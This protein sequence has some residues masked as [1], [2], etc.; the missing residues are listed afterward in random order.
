MHDILEMPTTMRQLAVVQFFTWFALFS[1]W[2]YGTPAVASFHFGATDTDSALYNEGA[3]WV[4]ILF[5]T[6]NGFAALA[7]I[8]IPLMIRAIGIRQSHMLNLILGA[9]A[10]LSFLWVKDPQWLLLSMVAMGFA[11]ASILAIPYSILSC[12][13]PQHKMG[14]YAGIFNLFIVIPQILASS[15]LALVVHHLFSGQP[16]YVLGL[17][18]LLLLVAAVATHFVEIETIGAEPNPAAAT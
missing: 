17:A 11:W 12:A 16:I 5:A 13:L 6:Y 10:M 2:I 8:A 4:G 1:L 14:T 7:A 3:N 18:G 15:L 9:G